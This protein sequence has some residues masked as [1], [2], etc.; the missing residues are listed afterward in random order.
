MS[1]TTL[2][3]II[4]IIAGLLCVQGCKK[5]SPESEPVDEA[6]K[7]AADYAQEAASEIDT[8]NMADELDRIEGEMAQE[9]AEMP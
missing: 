7:T 9:E 5:S 8:E 6:V 4:L 2:V 3:L 1:K